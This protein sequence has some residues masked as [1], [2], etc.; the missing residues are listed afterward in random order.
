VVYGYHSISNDGWRFSVTEN[1][2]KRQIESLL[3]KQE[4]ITVRDIPAYIRGDKR[5]T[6]DAFVVTFDDGYQDILTVRDFLESR[7]ICPTI[8]M[9][10]NTK[11]PNYKEL[12]TVRPFLSPQQIV[13][14]EQVGWEIGSHSATHA[15]FTDLS[16]SEMEYE[17]KGSR[18]E[19]EKIVGKTVTS[20]SYPKGVYDDEILKATRDGGFSMGFTIDD[21]YIGPTTDLLRVPRVG[22]DGTHSL[23]QFLIL[24]SPLAML[25]RKT[26]KKILRAV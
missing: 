24:S 22:V 2:F 25:M 5:L 20:F 23:S 15:N 11:E 7:G 10:S 3:Q 14:L 6:K 19:L 26:I 17:I 8:F 9:L 12:G 21:E 18:I 16:A 1:N 13:A 4:P